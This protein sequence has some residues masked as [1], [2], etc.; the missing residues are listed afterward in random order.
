MVIINNNLYRTLTRLLII[1]GACMLICQMLAIKQLF[2]AIIMV[3]SAA[4][5]HLI[6]WQTLPLY[7]SLFIII[8]YP[9]SFII[10]TIIACKNMRI[11]MDKK[12]FLYI[13]VPGIP[14]LYF[15]NIFILH[16]WY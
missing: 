12:A 14:A 2:I 4:T 5:P 10:F 7:L 1:I 11:G 3:L 15:F 16:Y 9:F 8:S 13:L 6:N